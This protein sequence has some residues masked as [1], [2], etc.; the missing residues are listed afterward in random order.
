ML[1]RKR[2]TEINFADAFVFDDFLRRSFRQD[3]AV[4]QNISTVDDVQR[5]ADVV[6]GNQ[7]AK[8]LK[9][10]IGDQIPDIRNGDWIDTGEWLVQK[11]ERG[12]GRQGAG[13]FN[14][15]AF[16]AGKGEG[17]AAADVRDGKFGQ[18]FLQAFRTGFGIVQNDFKGGHDVVFRRKRAEDGCF[19]RQITD[20]E[21]G[22]AIHGKMRD[23]DAVQRDFS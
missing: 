14:A 9:L 11:D 4:M 18:Q 22:A 20:T 3:D 7:N 21:A 19:L 2:R 1:N 10:Q 6:V 8:A 13:D 23:V 5:L 17:R 16:A 15:S 12:I